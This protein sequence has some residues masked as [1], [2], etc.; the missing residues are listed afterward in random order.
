MLVELFSGEKPIFGDTVERIFNQ[1]LNHPINLEP[2]R[3]KRVPPALIGLI[4]RC[5]ANPAE[6]APGFDV[7]CPE[8]ERILDSSTANFRTA[9]EPQRKQR[10]ASSRAVSCRNFR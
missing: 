3:A 4:A 7:I 10:P 9:P 8:V 1:I 2:L 5:T 6:H